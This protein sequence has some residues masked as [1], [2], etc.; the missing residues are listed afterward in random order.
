MIRGRAMAQDDSGRKP[1]F[2]QVAASVLASFLG[3]QSDKN[4]QRD[5]QHGKPAHFIIVG[6]L[7]TAAFVLVVWGVVQLVLRLAMG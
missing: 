1:G 2:L 6:L 4:R 3:V 7:L 5:F